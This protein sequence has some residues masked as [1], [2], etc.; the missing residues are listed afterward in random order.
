MSGMA[1]SIKKAAPIIVVTWILSL[2][3]TLAVVYVAPN[4]LPLQT[5]QISDNA[6][7]SKKIADSAIVTTKLADGS[8][9]SAKIQ[10]GNVNGCRLG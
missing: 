7:T 6:I 5:T 8:V 4:I 9:T 2:V 1:T 10:N 3:S